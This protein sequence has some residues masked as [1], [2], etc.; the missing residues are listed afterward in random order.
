MTQAAVDFE[1]ISIEEAL[2]RLD[3]DQER[4]LT[5]AKAEQKLEEYGFNEIPEKEE[6]LAHRVFR[7]F[8]GPIPWMIEAAALLSALVKKWEDFAIIAAL[9]FANAFIDF[10]QESR[11]LNALSVL[12]EKLAKKAIVLRD[13][14]FRTIDARYLVPGDIIKIRIGDVVPADVKLIAGDFIQADQSALTG[15]SLP[16]S[17]KPGD[18]AY[19]NSVVKQGEM[20]GVVT[21]TAANTFFGRTVAL[22]ARAEREQKSHFQKA[23][24]HI[25]NYLIVI[26]IFL[27]AVILI[28]ALFRHENLLEILRFALVLTVAAIPVAMPAV[29]TVTLAAGA[30]KLA[31]KQ[32]I[33]SRLV[34]IEELAG[35]DVLCSDK[36][37]T[38][39]QNRMTVSDPVAFAGHTVEELMVFAALCSR[40][41]NQDPIE[42]P[43]FEYLQGREGLDSLHSYRQVKFTPFDPVSKKT[44]AVVR[45]GDRDFLVTKGAPQVI[46]DLC[47]E[48]FD[49][50]EVLGKVEALAG[51]GYRTLGVAA[52]NPEDPHYAF[53][54]LIPLFDP[55][56]EDSQATTEEAGKLGLD[57]KMVTGDNIAIARHIAESLGIGT[58]IF[59]AR[60]LRGASTRELVLLGAVI[61][62][63]IYRKMSP[64]VP[65]KEAERFAAEVV[66]ALEREL[67]DIALP[68]GYVKRHESEII[69]VIE[70]ASGFAQV[71]PEDKYLIVDRLQK[72]GHIVGMTGDGV[73]D[74][75]ALK[76]ADAGIAVSGATDAA[77]AAADLVL[78]APG[79]S[80]IVDAV[81]EAR[82]TF[83][84][85]KSYSIFR[86]AET[87]RVILFMTASIVV[88]NFYPV[89][90]IMIIILAFLNDVPI[91]TI[92]YDNTKVNEGPVR[93]NMAEVLTLAT[94]LGI[95]G[96]TASFGIFY[97]AREY[98]GLSPDV[99]QSFIFLKLIVAGHSTIYVTRTER[100]FWQR[101]FPS[102]LLFSAT[103]FTEIVG[104][105]FAVYGLFLTAIG[106]R[107]ALLIWAYA[108]TWFLLNDLIKVWT[109]K[110]LRREKNTA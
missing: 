5:T 35:V 69:E 41:E 21:H 84:R 97:I 85:M 53:M 95:S 81:K 24:L 65:A 78:L 47:G 18:I 82:V 60:D 58:R 26:T 57:V 43:I 105:L 36:T 23:V 7:R 62:R 30:M 45:K 71:F 93:W 37:G 42:I 90:A 94:I 61:A 91:L 101:P 87:I 33:V 67:A 32:A 12:K 25:G 15:E 72:A 86:V 108:L 89:T 88:F 64:E 4:G 83:E 2:R 74:A 92:A 11:A 99:V 46:L 68:E 79:L 104:T 70:N 75:P 38:L 6:S 29:L 49:R 19:S 51:Q 73:N 77:R 20:L 16:V 22:V 50:E 110:Y 109:Y 39:T 55:P 106:W 34:A 48:Q 102:P 1:K 100:H 107:Y 66:K 80:V 28:A 8:W 76:K 3:G 54:G 27:V 59:D 103:F 63:T 17:K 52:R 31:K 14:K 13:G 96:V 56:R 40:E 10:W 9:L 44:E 98:M